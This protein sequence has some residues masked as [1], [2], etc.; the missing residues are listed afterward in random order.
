MEFR[1]QVFE[2]QPV[3]LDGNSYVD[4]K[5]LECTLTFSG[6]AGVSFDGCLF[7]RCRWNFEGAAATTLSFL[8]ALNAGIRDGSGS[9]VF[10]ALVDA[11]KD[12]HIVGAQ[13]SPELAAR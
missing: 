3:E 9:S 4:C 12:G 13:R 5:F 10:D 8:N 7:R 6:V 11:I 1:S 2:Q